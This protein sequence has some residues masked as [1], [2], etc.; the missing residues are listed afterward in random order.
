MW[1]PATEIGRPSTVRSTTMAARCRGSERSWRRGTT[2]HA[3]TGSEGRTRTAIPVDPGCARAG[4][5]GN[6]G[7]ILAAGH[8]VVVDSTLSGNT[9]GKGGLLAN[10]CA[11]QAASGVGAGLAV[12]GG[13]SVVTYSTVAG[14]TDGIDNVA[15]TVTLTGTIVADSAT[16]NC[17]GA[18]AEGAGHNLDSATTCGFHATGDV[19]GAAPLLGALAANGGPTATRALLAG[20]PAIDAGA[21]ATSGCP[22][23]DQRGLARPDESSDAGR[24]DIGAFESQHLA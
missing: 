6:G 2:R 8:L 12:T 10:P 17:T 9:T 1:M 22:A 11:G 7:A 16:A 19:S 3:S 21:T 15:G 5:G 23:K 24:C 18:I 14:N 13:T 20:S 4:T